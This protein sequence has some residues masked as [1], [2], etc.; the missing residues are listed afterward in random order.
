[1]CY[2][3]QIWGSDNTDASVRAR[4][5]NNYSYAYP[6]ETVSAHISDCPNHQT[7]RSVSLD[8]RYAV[9]AFGS[10]G[11]ECNLCDMNRGDYEAVARQIELYKAWR[12]VFQKGTFYRCMDG[13]VVSWCVVSEIRRVRL[14]YVIRI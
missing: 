8:T 11:Y 1:M 2:F 6:M 13:N 3:P 5:Q 12:R 14:A 7:L 4:I 10:L 9:A